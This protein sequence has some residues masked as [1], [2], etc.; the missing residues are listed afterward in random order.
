[1]SA[2][3]IIL[4][5][6]AG[7][8]CRMIVKYSSQLDRGK[9]C[10]YRGQIVNMGRARMIRNTTQ[11][12]STVQIIFFWCFDGAVPTCTSNITQDSIQNDSSDLIHPII[13]E[14]Y[15][16]AFVA[17]IFAFYLQRAIVWSINQ[18]H[19]HEY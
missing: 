14:I 16:E 10:V 1:M 11:Q 19:F 17:R 18:L 8:S 5:L 6:R 3:V 2:K 4:R 9:P 15:G 12:Y 13:L 7:A